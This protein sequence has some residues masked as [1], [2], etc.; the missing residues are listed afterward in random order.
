MCLLSFSLEASLAGEELRICDDQLSKRSEVSAS[1]LS[2]LN[3]RLWMT[4]LY[5]TFHPKQILLY[6]IS[7]SDYAVTVS[8]AVLSRTVINHVDNVSEIEPRN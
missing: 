4:L 8:R 1:A 7:R 2:I 3:R 5:R 6:G